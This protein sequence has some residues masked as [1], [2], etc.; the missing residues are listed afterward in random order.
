VF[1]TLCREF[2][3][4]VAMEENIKALHSPLGYLLVAFYSAISNRFVTDF[5]GLERILL[6]VAF[7]E[8]CFQ[9]HSLRV[10]LSEHQTS[11]RVRL[12]A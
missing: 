5:L 3:A 7:V 2:V 10:F 6:V 8:C 4:T 12:P 11:N 9:K 1:K